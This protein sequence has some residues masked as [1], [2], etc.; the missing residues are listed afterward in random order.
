MKKIVLTYL[1]T[2]F[3]L[4][5]MAQERDHQ[6]ELYQ[7][8]LVHHSLEDVFKKHPLYEEMEEMY[9]SGQNYLPTNQVFVLKNSL[10]G[11]NYELIKFEQLCEVV[12][13]SSILEHKIQHY[14]E[15]TGFEINNNETKA[16]VAFVYRYPELFNMT[17]QALYG[18]IEFEKENERWKA[19]DHRLHNELYSMR[20]TK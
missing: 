12:P 2:A 16:E 5:A 15:F 20:V 7:R 9:Q 10:I 13:M 17:N 1:F 8:T 19:T 4:V 14:I 6:E 11:Y 18:V 3:V